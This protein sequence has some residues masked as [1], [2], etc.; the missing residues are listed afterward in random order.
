MVLNLYPP[1]F[2]SSPLFPSHIPLHMLV[3]Y[4]IP[5]RS[6]CFILYN[7]AFCFIPCVISENKDTPTTKTYFQLKILDF[8][9]LNFVLK[10]E[11]SKWIWI[12][13]SKTVKI[14]GNSHFLY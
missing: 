10:I 4:F 1:C 14:S 13:V 6:F 9:D 8:P 12:F 3:I 7:V 2:F 11:N 5:H